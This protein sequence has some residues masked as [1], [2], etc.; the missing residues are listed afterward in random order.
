MEIGSL[1]GLTRLRLSYNDFRGSVPTEFQQLSQLQLIQLNGNRL[2]GSV[3]PLMDTQLKYGE[4]SFVSDCG[5][6]SAY[7]SPLLCDECSMCCKFLTTI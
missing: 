4:S 2:I 7:E 1:V 6:P 5:S 3:P